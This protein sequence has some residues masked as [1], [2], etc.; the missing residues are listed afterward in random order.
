[1]VLYIF[2]KLGIRKILMGEFVFDTK[3]VLPAKRP[4][5]H[6]LFGNGN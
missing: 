6:G 1:M 3:C 4:L 2:F 5:I